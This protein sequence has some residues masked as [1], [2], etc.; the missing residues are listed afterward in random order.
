MLRPEVLDMNVVV[1]EVGL[2][3]S[4]LI[5]EDIE[6]VIEHGAGAAAGA[7]RPV[8]SSSRC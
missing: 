2:L 1:R 3:I 6:L 7:R 4:R 5:G 8:A